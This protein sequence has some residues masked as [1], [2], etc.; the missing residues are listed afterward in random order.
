MPELAVV[1]IRGGVKAKRGAVETMKLLGLNRVNHCVVLDKNQSILGML[2]KAKDYLTWGEINAETL[3]I[4][5]R[6][7]GRTSGN[8]PLTDETVKN[9]TGFQTI[10]ELASAIC[11]GKAELNDIKEIKKVF[12]LHPPRKGYRS[13]KRPYRDLGDLGYRG[14]AINELIKRMA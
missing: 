5:L 4:L 9:S 3:E 11:E 2:Q 8:R 6:K 14:D 1:R 7:R 10:A 13:V 12:R